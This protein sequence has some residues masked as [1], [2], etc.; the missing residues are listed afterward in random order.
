MGPTWLRR[1]IATVAGL[2]CVA[3][4]A[5]ASDPPESIPLP[6]PA[7]PAPDGS[8]SLIV[9]PPLPVAPTGSASRVT[10][11][12]APRPEPEK[13]ESPAAA[14]GETD[15]VGVREAATARL[16][17]LPKE[18][19]KEE[20]AASKTLREVLGERTTWLD[21]WDKAVKE[22]GD[23]ENPKPS[24]EAQAAEWKADLERIKATLGESNDDPDALIP[25]SFRNLPAEVPAKVLGEMK[26]AIDAAQAEL[27]ELTGKH[28]QFRADSSRTDASSLAKI[29]ASRDKV[30]QR[31]A[32]L[33]TRSA[34][35]EAAVAGAK[36]PEA[37]ALARDRLVNF[38]WE[39]RVENERLK[40]LEARLTL[41]TKRSELA[42]LNLQVLQAHV[43]VAQR[44]LDRLKTRYRAITA[45]QELDLRRAAVA[46]KSR[47]K[48]VEDPIEKYRATRTSDLLELE[49]RVVKSE[50][51]Q[52]A[53]SPPTLEQQRA[54]ADTADNDLTNVKKLMDDG[55]ISRLEALRLTNDFRRIGA[56]HA[57]IVRNELAV[58]AT[59]LA[60]A[61]AA[62]SDVETE[63]VY[64]SQDRYELDALLERLPRSLHPK[65]TAVFEELE[66]K[67]T[68]LLTRRRGALEKLAR[69]AEE[70]HEQVL[71]R[72]RI[73]DDHFGFIRTNLFWVRDE[74]PIGMTTVTQLQREAWQLLRASVQT[75]EDF[76]DRTNWGRLS[77]EFLSATLGLIVLPWPL[78]RVR[79][80]L[81]SYDARRW[82]AGR[83][84]TRR[85]G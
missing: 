3:L 80:G 66:H 74:E 2:G 54:L 65:A 29:R 79:R 69:R 41:E 16:T 76:L 64:E 55:R 27:K 70:T 84:R 78:L 35:R 61:E 51:A 63:L 68:E 83:S 62:L 6:Q 5:G 31:V 72:L 9:L 32:G 45:R 40:G 46:E 26:E 23:A 1:L 15:P 22:R 20:T 8:G 7:A 60:G 42:V 71:R 47:S 25:T 21:E 57:R 58:T 11:G 43:Q 67:H 24:P 4:A 59:R 52:A 17:S 37:L 77:P 53:G 19:S 33:K 75:A 30:H 38:Q 44:T 34:E 85:G 13:V 12:D 56:E 39:S 36:G 49:A 10:P 14:T 50:S 73:L 28:E 82:D 48:K 81:R 18:K